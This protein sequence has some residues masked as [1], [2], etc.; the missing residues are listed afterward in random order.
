MQSR[1]TAGP[2]SSSHLPDHEPHRQRISRWPSSFKEHT[3]SKPASNASLDAMHDADRHASG[4]TA[5]HPGHDKTAPLHEHTKP[6]G[7]LREV[8]LR[9]DSAKVMH[10]ESRH[11]SSDKA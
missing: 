5:S 4:D 9:E 1:K 3:M 2:E 7:D 6:Q 11:R 8:E 10:G